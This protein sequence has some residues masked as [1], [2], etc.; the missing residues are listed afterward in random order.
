[1]NMNPMAVVLWLVSWG[2]IV[3]TTVWCFYR[4]LVERRKK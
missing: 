3:V 1:M 2:V 4:M